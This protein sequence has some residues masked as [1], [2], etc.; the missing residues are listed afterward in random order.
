ME[1]QHV[2]GPTQPIVSFVPSPRTMLWWLLRPDE[3]LEAEPQQLVKRL[4]QISSSWRYGSFAWCGSG[5]QRS[6]EL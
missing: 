3:Q 4:C 1:Q 6:S 2:R 5:G